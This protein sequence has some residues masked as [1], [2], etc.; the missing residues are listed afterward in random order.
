MKSGQ[1]ERAHVV[2]VN[3]RRDLEGNDRFVQQARVVLGRDSI[4]DGSK[5]KVF[6]V[7]AKNDEGIEPFVREGI[8]VRGGAHHGA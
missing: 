4:D 8:L 1:S 2:A 5:R 3:V 6:P 7:D